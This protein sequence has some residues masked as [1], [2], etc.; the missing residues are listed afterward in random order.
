MTNTTAT[1]LHY[2]IVGSFLRPAELKAAREKFKAGEIS[3]ADLHQ[4]ED[5]AIEDLVAKEKAH[6]LK[7]VTDGEF[8]RSWW[9][10]DTFWGF[11]GVKKIERQQG[12]TFH[13][14]ETRAESAQVSGKV[15]FS[16]DHPDLAAYKFLH[17]LTVND[18][19]ISDRQSIPAPAQLYAELIRGEK[20]RQAIAKYYSNEAD[21]VADIGQAYHDLLLALY[22]AG[23][24]DVKFD[25]CTW[26][27]IVDD[28]YWK[29]RIQEG[30]SRDE[31]AEAYLKVNNAALVDLPEDLQVTT[32]VCR[33]NYH[34]TWA[35]AGGYAPIADYL[36][37]RENVKSFYLEY[38][39]SRSGDFAPLAKVAAGKDVVLGLVTSKHP[40][41]ED[42]QTL[43]KRV[44]EASQFVPLE[45]LALSTQCGF[46]ST[47]EGNKLTE[48]QQWD[49]IELVIDVANQIWK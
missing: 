20:N 35:A 24:R 6:G 47:E 16:S 41:L 38:D 5:Q 10:L 49:K 39:D 18:P 34:S 21:L 3:V 15:A 19:E 30:F 8:R 27:M 13:D 17:T 43:I 7:V 1:K 31:L 32:H 9:H 46:A 2:D 37:A 26:G 22:D 45:H 33:G 23:C 12:Y 36:F 4:A 29:N 11:S 28:N 25:D 14:E 44:E 48:K 40:E 42:S